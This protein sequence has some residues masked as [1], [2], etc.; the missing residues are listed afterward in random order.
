MCSIEAVLLDLL[1][2][3]PGEEEDLE[4]KL[5]NFEREKN[6]VLENKLNEQKRVDSR[7]QLQQFHKD[8]DG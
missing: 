8:Q 1:G 3:M 7:M 4:R 6:K 5:N 2:H